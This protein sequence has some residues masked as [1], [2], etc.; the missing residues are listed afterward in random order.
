VIVAQ[1]TVQTDRAAGM[2][3][4]VVQGRVDAPSGAAAANRLA[5]GASTRPSIQPS[6]LPWSS[7]A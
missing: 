1:A 5:L 7:L 3:H 4:G 6:M 2:P